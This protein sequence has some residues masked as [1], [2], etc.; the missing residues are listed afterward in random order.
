MVFLHS[1]VLHCQ[2]KNY[3]LLC[4]LAESDLAGFGFVFKKDHV[5]KLLRQSHH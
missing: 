5:I 1:G 4:T 3:F 2:Q